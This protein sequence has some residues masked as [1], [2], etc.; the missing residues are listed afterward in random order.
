MTGRVVL[1][2]IRDSLPTKAWLSRHSILLL[3]R[4]LEC[5]S[6][7]LLECEGISVQDGKKAKGKDKNLHK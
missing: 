3:R 4:I 7:V 5:R 1:Y 2:I 6:R